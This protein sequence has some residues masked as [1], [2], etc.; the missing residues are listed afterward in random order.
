MLAPLAER[1]RDWLARGRQDL[2][3]VVFYKPGLHLL[4]DR[5]LSWQP[6]SQEVFHETLCGHGGVRLLGRLQRGRL[7]AT[8]KMPGASVARTPDR[9]SLPSSGRR[10]EAV[11]PSSAPLDSRWHSNSEPTLFCAKA[12]GLAATVGGPPARTYRP[13]LAE[14]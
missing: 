9:G 12:N 7:R 5:S 3:V 8:A 10:L 4:L 11:R 6:S 13:S 14:S 2:L 1:R